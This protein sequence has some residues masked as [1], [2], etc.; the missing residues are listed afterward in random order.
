MKR[1]ITYGTYDLYHEGHS[2]LLERARNLG[3]ELY[4]GLS[5]DAFNA[6]KGKKAI[7]SYALRED[8]L[9]KSGY[10]SHVF[11][12]NNWQQKA[13]D[14]NLYHAEILVMGDDWEGK[15]DHFSHLCEVRYLKRTPGISSTML[16]LEIAMNA[17][18]R[19]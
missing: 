1:I 13:K 6:I 15:F 3:D 17:R 14:I 16:R 5:T 7:H 12:E 19:Q 10:V 4:V 11:E 18:L 9:L 2:R 8:N